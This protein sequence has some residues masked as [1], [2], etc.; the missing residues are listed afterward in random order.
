M[1][2]MGFLIGLC[3]IMVF[4]IALFDNNKDKED[5]NKKKKGEDDYDEE[6]F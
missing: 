5:K 1:V 2:I 3:I 4:C 6:E